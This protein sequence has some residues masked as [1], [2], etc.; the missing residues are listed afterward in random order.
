[1]V[2]AAQIFL[3]LTTAFTVFAMGYTIYATVRLA[4]RLAKQRR[5]RD[6]ADPP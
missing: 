3:L 4:W 5:D 2:L 1:M 6:R